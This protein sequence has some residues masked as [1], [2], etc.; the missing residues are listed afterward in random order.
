MYRGNG[1]RVVLKVSLSGLSV[2]RK[3]WDVLEKR[4]VAPGLWRED[5]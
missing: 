3:V 5:V 4:I 1:E 2:V